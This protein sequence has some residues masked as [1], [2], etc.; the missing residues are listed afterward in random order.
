MNDA[1]CAVNESLLVDQCEGGHRARPYGY[2]PFVIARVDGNRPEAIRVGQWIKR[3]GGHRARPYG[4]IPFVV[5]RVDGNR[6][7]A[8]SGVG[9]GVDL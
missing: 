7:E 3:E 8:I 4:H 1:G 6:P 9:G 5:A 2:I